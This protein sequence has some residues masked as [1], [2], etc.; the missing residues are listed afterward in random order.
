MSHYAKVN[1]FGIVEDVI[2]ADQSFIDSLPDASSWIQ[3]SYNTRGGIYYE[4]NTNIPSPDQSK[5]FRK[6]FAGVGFRFDPVLNAFIPL[7]PY[8]SW[9]LDTTSCLWE[10]PNKKPTQ[11]YWEWDEQLQEWVEL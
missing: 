9:I 4:S 2:V 3:T 5:A 7:Q 1:G 11:G 6:N 8:P 10:A